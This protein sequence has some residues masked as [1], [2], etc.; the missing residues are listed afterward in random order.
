MRQGRKAAS[1]STRHYKGASVPSFIGFKPASEAASKAKRANRRKD[2]G[3]E[4]LLRK[5]IWRLGLRYRKHVKSLPGRPDLVFSQARVVVF[6]DGDFWHGRNWR[7]L[8]RQLARRHNADYWLAKIARN[9]DR[10]R[11]NNRT[12]QRGGWRAVR[13]WDGRWSHF[14]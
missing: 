11:Q 1:Q 2:T 5:T 10:D 8:R 13:L 14:P 7:Q 6:C 12:L 4:L 3:H 9:R